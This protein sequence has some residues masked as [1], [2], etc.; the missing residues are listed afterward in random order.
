MSIGCEDLKIHRTIK[1]N[2][3]GKA[4]GYKKIV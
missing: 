2:V 1:Y 3:K 4:C